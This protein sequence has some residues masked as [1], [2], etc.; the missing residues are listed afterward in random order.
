MY[1]YIYVHACT[2]CHMY[3]HPCTLTIVAYAHGYVDQVDAY[4]QYEFG[5]TRKCAIE[6][7]CLW[8]IFFGFHGE[9]RVTLGELQLGL[10]NGVYLL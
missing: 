7:Q 4:V 3:G 6:Q 2:Y 5:H 10:A 1:M 9:R 8:D